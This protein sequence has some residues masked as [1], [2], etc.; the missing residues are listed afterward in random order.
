VVEL[1]FLLTTAPGLVVLV[2]L[3]R[4]LSNLPL[5]AV[6]AVPLGPALSAA[7]YALYHRRSD[8]ADLHPASDF[9]RGYRLNG[10]SALLVW[11]PG[12]AWLTVIA[13]SLANFSAAGVPGWWA[14]LLVVL[15]GAVA[16]WVLNALVITS[17]FAFRTV[18]VARLAAYFL[19]RTPSVALGGA[20]LLIAAVGVAVLA[21]E[22]VLALLGWLFVAALL[23]TSRPMTTRIREEFTA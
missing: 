1:L 9:W 8:L 11:V 13:V 14:A 4:D 15:A 12:L 21:S 20:G 16:L 7:L 19:I 2:L 23:A 18:D 5:A 6:C 3:D 17:L 22:A 10:A